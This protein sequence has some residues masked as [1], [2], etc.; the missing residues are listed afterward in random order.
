MVGSADLAMVDNI[1]QQPVTNNWVLHED[2]D[3]ATTN[4]NND[5]FICL[6]D[7]ADAD[8]L[9]DGCVRMG[10]LNDLPTNDPAA[11]NH[12][13]GAEW[14]GGFFDSTGKHFYV[15]IQHNMTGF[16]V[17]LDITG[18]DNVGH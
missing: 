11:A 18:F 12:G 4:K 13:E 1:A 9:T 10:T 8:T 6:A 14:T 17:V 16:G 3:I 2:G 15:S 5:L 7:G